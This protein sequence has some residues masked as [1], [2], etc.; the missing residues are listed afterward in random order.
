[1]KQRTKL[2]E[3]NAE[4]D[5]GRSIRRR[6]CMSISDRNNDFIALF[7]SS[8][9]WHHL[10]LS[11]PILGETAD[12]DTLISWGDARAVWSSLFALY[13][14]SFALSLSPYNH[15]FLTPSLTHPESKG[16][17]R[18][19]PCILYSVHSREL[20]IHC[21]FDPNTFLCIVVDHF[22]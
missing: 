1:M 6:V 18:P 19:A 4:A 10:E 12:R 16:L 3:T 13:S 20:R 21:V 22:P 15:T 2:I 9:S 11:F 17:F 7:R 5:S 14:R 8:H